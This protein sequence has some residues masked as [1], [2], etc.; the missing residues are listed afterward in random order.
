[1]SVV[2]LVIL[3]VSAVE[4]VVV[5]EVVV[6][7]AVVAEAPDTAGALAMVGGATVLV[8]VAHRLAV[9][10]HHL[11]EITIAGHHHIVDERSCHMQTEMGLRTGVVA[12]ADDYGDEVFKCSGICYLC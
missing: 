12:G 3:L 6:D 7:V 11:A 8:A 9:V 10:L 4:V 2:N 1:M 5:V